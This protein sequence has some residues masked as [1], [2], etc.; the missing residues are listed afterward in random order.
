M[1]E[2]REELY[3][4]TQ[5]LCKKKFELNI[6]GEAIDDFNFGWAKVMRLTFLMDVRCITGE[7]RIPGTLC[8]REMCRG[9]KI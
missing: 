9:N 1:T 8:P 6:A 7:L 2:Q 3:A 5:D 4:V